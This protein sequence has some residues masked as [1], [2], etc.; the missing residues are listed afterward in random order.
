MYNETFEIKST[1]INRVASSGTNRD[2]TFKENR[3][4]L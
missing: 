3:Q 4:R 1:M 2:R